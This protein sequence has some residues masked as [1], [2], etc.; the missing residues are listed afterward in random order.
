MSK[1]EAEQAYHKLMALITSHRPGSM[2]LKPEAHTLS[3]SSLPLATP[4]PTPPHSPL[5]PTM[6]VLLQTGHNGS[7]VPKKFNSSCCSSI[8][9]LLHQL[10]DS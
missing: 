7:T 8:N 1:E 4:I 3:L 10:H 2:S 5:Q 6:A 9:Q